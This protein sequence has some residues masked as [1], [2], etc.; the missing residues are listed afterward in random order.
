MSFFFALI[1]AAGI[2]VLLWR[3]TLGYELRTLGA[4]PTAAVYAGMRP[5]RLT[6]L[7]MAISG[8]L[9]GFLALNE[10]M[11]SQHRLILDF[12]AGYGF[13]GIAVA[14]MGRSHPVGV[15]LAALLF[16]ALYQGGAELSFEKP[17]ITRDLVVVIQG[18]VVFFS[19]ALEH[20]FRPKIEAGLRRI[21]ARSSQASAEGA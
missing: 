4:N 20:A 18:L 11:G 10:I 17:S 14:L 2:W 13:G 21:L 6:V 3:T 15:L 16:G 5:K 19:G 1:C 7:A 9:A 8:G 12:T